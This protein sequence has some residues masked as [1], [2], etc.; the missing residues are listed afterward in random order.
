MTSK[1]KK[2]DTLY[3][4]FQVFNNNVIVQNNEINKL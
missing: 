1:N 3:R 2:F 4:N